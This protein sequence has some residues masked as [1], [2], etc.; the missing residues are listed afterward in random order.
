MIKCNT[1]NIKQFKGKK[2]TTL[3]GLSAPWGYGYPY[4]INVQKTSPRPIET[5]EYMQRRRR[6]VVEN[7]IEKTIKEPHKISRYKRQPYSRRPYKS[8]FRQDESIKKTARRQDIIDE[9]ISDFTEQDYLSQ[10]NQDFLRAFDAWWVDHKKDLKS[11]HKQLSDKKIHEKYSKELNAAALD[12]SQ[13]ENKQ[14]NDMLSDIEKQWKAEQDYITQQ[15]NIKKDDVSQ[16]KLLNQIMDELGVE[17]Q[18]AELYL[19]EAP[20]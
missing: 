16:R 10:H 14:L 15:E 18:E 3:M 6:K 9:A 5:K 2:K 4:T 8:A 13:Q 7:G 19:E 11:V 12:I 1:L 17:E 20:F